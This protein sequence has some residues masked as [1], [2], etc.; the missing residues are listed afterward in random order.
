MFFKTVLITRVNGLEINEMG[1]EF[2]NGIQ[3]RFMRANGKTI[4]LKA[5]AE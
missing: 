1:V 4:K 2:K 5:T 3:V